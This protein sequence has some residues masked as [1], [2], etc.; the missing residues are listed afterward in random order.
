LFDAGLVVDGWVVENSLEL[1]DVFEGDAGGVVLGFECFEMDAFFDELE[2]AVAVLVS[3]L[4]VVAL[5]LGAIEPREAVKDG[6]VKGGI[7]QCVAGEL[8]KD[9]REAWK[10][11]GD[12]CQLDVLSEALLDVTFLCVTAENGAAEREAN[13][14][15]FRLRAEIA[16]LIKSLF[17]DEDPMI[18]FGELL[19]GEFC[20][21]TFAMWDIWDFRDFRDCN[22]LHETGGT[23]GNFHGR[24]G[25]YGR[26]ELGL[27]GLRLEF[28]RRSFSLPG[29]GD[30]TRVGVGPRLRADF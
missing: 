1:I 16:N 9:L 19:R 25:L 29:N 7:E 15:G 28:H 17:V 4:L 13:A 22:R 23:S 5:V 18:E 11:L 8:F 12:L 30:G 14:M 10:R 2:V 6:R 20:E 24:H 3:L 27:V 26:R 21:R